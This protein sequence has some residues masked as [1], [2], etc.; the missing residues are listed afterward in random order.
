MMAL[1]QQHPGTLLK[2]QF[3]FITG[4]WLPTPSAETPNTLLVMVQSL[5]K[6]KLSCFLFAQA[7]RGQATSAPTQSGG[8]VLLSSPKTQHPPLRAGTGGHSLP[9][10]EQTA[11]L[12]S[13]SQV[14]SAIS[15]LSLC[16]NTSWQSC[17][18]GRVAQEKHRVTWQTG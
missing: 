14:S 3:R 8:S 9:A 10:Q 18:C 12:L 1:A 4:T 2:R 11:G 17:R 16:T 5:H 15:K 7:V 6:Q 13:P